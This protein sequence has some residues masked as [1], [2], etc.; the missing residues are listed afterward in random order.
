MTVLPAPPV[1]HPAASFCSTASPS[2]VPSA[3]MILAP[4]RE[5]SL[6]CINIFY[7]TLYCPVDG[8]YPYPVLCAISYEKP[9]LAYCKTW[10]FKHC[11]LEPDVITLP[12]SFLYRCQPHQAAHPYL[13]LTRQ[14]TPLAPQHQAAPQTGPWPPHS[15][16]CSSSS[17][18]SA[19]SQGSKLYHP[20]SLLTST[21]SESLLKAAPMRLKVS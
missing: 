12:I 17:S 7:C 3:T 20:T 9:R 8:Q 15:S 5:R 21:S 1:V 16:N 4:S 18:H 11:M 14:F 6:L 2:A 19:N 10:V 13:P